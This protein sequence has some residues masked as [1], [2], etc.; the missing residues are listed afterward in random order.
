[1]EYN[2]LPFLQNIAIKNDWWIENL[3]CCVI[4]KNFQRNLILPNKQ[5]TISEK[6]T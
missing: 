4:S 5:I 3:V 2:D 1:M 6:Y